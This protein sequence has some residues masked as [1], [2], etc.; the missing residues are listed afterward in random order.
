MK[1]SGLTAE[2]RSIRVE[3]QHPFCVTNSQVVSASDGTLP[4][5]LI[6]LYGHT[7]HTLFFTCSFA[8]HGGVGVGIGVGRGVGNGVGT[9]EE[10]GLATAL[11]KESVKVS[12]VGLVMGLATA[13]VQESVKVSVVGM[14][15]VVVAV[16]ET[17]VLV[18]LLLLVLEDEDVDVVVLD[19][20]DVLELVV[21]VVS[22]TYAVIYST[23]SSESDVIPSAISE[24]CV[25][26]KTNAIRVCWMGREPMLECILEFIVQ[27]P[28]VPLLWH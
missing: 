6:V 1:V 14:R 23:A 13:L 10:V 19:E 16:V 5:R 8:W 26:V 4:A 7:S 9:A 12:V 21:V 25:L 11:V 17:V 22:D 2:S 20:V 24:G 28:V 18:L 27:S 3:R 15:M